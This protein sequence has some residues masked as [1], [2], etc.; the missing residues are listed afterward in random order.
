MKKVT[1]LALI[2]A[3]V[4]MGLAVVALLAVNLYVQSHA[5]QARIQHELSQRLG[6]PLHIQRISVTPWWGLKLTGITMPQEN[7]AVQSDFLKADTFRLRVRVA[8]LF[9]RRLVITE[10]SLINPKVV[11]AQNDDGKWRLPAS[12]RPPPPEPGTEPAAP[13]PGVPPPAVSPELPP[14]DLAA[15]PPEPEESSGQFT[16]EVRRVYLSNGSFRFLDANQKPVATFEGVRFRSD[17]REASEVRGRISIA[18]TSLRDRFFLEQL[19]SPLKYDATELEFTDIRA[20]A[21]GGE[22]RGQFEL[23]PGEAESPFKVMVKFSALEADQLVADAG[24]PVGMVEGHIDGHLEAF[25]NTADPEALKGRGEI[26]L[27]D[28]QLRQYSLLV[29]LGQLLRI[30]ELSQLQFEQAHVKYR[31]DPGVVTIDELLLISPDIRLSATGTVDFRGRLRL[32]SQLAINERIRAQLFRP[33]RENFLPIGEPGYAAVNFQISGT[34]ERP[35]T[36]LVDKVVGPELRDLGG[37]L[38]SLLGRGKSERGQRKR[39]R[40]A[41]AAAQPTAAEAAAA[42]TPLEPPVPVPVETTPAADALMDA[43][44]APPPLQPAELDEEP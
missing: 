34:L 4:L 3:G 11:W 1:R 41:A 36:N 39:D 37:M 38:N 12:L 6:T 17:L 13:A 43:T 26:V 20:R 16:P 32:E 9:A 40:G 30:E 14:S 15:V 5:T 24:G 2:V 31:I 28:G 44:P 8:S 42:P 22:I 21:A 19:Q 29:A 33:V 23:S 27:R 10:V 7:T 25:G 35:R 18:K